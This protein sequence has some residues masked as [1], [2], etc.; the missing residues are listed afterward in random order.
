[1]RKLYYIIAFLF[2]SFFSSFPTLMA[3]ERIP[4]IEDIK[5]DFNKESPEIR[6]SANIAVE[7]LDYALD[8]PS[9]IVIDP[10]GVVYTNLNEKVF[11]GDNSVK[12]VSII[13][14]KGEIPAELDRS[15]Y[16]L[17]FIVIEL[18]NPVSYDILREEKLVVRLGREVLR[19]APVSSPESAI[20]RTEAVELPAVKIADVKKDESV[21]QEF[22]DE[23]KF[24]VGER[25]RIDR[26]DQLE[27]SVWQHPDLLR[28]LVVRPDGFI[29]FPLA[30]D[31]KAEG[32]TTEKLAQEVS[33]RLSRTLRKPEVSVIIT[34]SAS[35]GI[36]VLGAVNKPGLYPYETRMTILKAVSLAGSWQ[37]YAYLKNVLVVK[38]F[39]NNENA[40]V[41]RI[42]LLDI[43][44]NGKLKNDIEL[45]TG[46]IVYVPKT[47][48]GNLNEFLTALRIG[49]GTSASFD[50]NQ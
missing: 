12:T 42:N 13:K 50:L 17:D 49:F 18:K 2:L 27:I 23:S 30:G 10:L 14:V 43:V 44:Q 15:Y 21:G 32:S 26:G 11:S 9:R 29:S 45:Q 31:I 1:M 38:R 33:L 22:F 34:G 4:I 7:Y 3:Q 47:F 20:Q 41:I 39:F 35:K 48:I 19:A 28:T 25:Y 37:N 6:I 46:D 5:I 40:E 8:K 24:P 36:F 16:P